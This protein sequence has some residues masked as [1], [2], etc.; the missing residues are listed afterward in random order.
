MKPS[1]MPLPY[2]FDIFE[3]SIVSRTGQFVNFIV[4]NLDFNLFKMN[5]PEPRSRPARGRIFRG[6]HI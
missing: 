3:G 5:L 2:P 6:R 1:A 4:I